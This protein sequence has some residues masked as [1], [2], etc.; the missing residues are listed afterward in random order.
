MIKP[1]LYAVLGGFDFGNGIYYYNTMSVHD[2]L[3]TSVQNLF[4]C[5]YCTNK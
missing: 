2:K 5:L 1:G 3:S 4:I